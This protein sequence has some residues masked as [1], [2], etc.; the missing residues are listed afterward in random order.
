M[1]IN[2]MEK[3]VLIGLLL[4]SLACEAAKLWLIVNVVKAIFAGELLAAVVLGVLA[5]VSNYISGSFAE[6]VEEYL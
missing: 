4:F 6:A 5:I 1:K 3:A 2:V